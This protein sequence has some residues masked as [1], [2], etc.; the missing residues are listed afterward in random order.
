MNPLLGRV[1]LFLFV[2]AVLII[3]ALILARIA[4]SGLSEWLLTSQQETAETEA[5]TETVVVS[6]VID[7]DTIVLTDRRRVRYVGLN[8]PEMAKK[9]KAAQCF[10]DQA[11]AQN[12]KL[13]LGKTIKLEKDSSNRD[14]YGRLLRLVYVT[15]ETGQEIFV[16]DYLLR[17]GLARVLNT[18]PDLRFEVQ[19]NAAAEEARFQ[20][21]GLWATCYSS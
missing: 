11:K 2:G 5:D 17:Q 16:N 21:R 18:P 6:Q 9:D 19:F 1:K 4:V 13:V 15:G 8:A 7:G 3:L 10:A 14:K 20:E 12:E